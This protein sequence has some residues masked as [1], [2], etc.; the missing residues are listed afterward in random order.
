MVTETTIQPM[1]EDVI[2]TYSTIPN[3]LRNLQ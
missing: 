3:G 2:V 1:S